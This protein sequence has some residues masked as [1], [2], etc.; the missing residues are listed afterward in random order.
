MEETAAVLPLAASW[1]PN[2]KRMLDWIITLLEPLAASWR[3][4]RKRMEETGR[5]SVAPAA[6]SIR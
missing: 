2:R 5:A 3:P 4:D 1:R 6:K